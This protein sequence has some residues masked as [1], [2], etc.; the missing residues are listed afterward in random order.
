MVYA[1]GRSVNPSAQWFAGVR[2][3]SHIRTGARPPRPSRLFAFK[4][5]GRAF[6]R[7]RPRTSAASGDV[8]CFARES[9]CNILAGTDHAFA[10]AM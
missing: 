8:T 6:F 7:P 4:G 9:A 10:R 5:F 1:T 2:T 3:V